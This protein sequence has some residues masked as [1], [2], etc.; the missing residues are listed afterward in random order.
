MECSMDTFIMECG[1]GT[2]PTRKNLIIDP[3]AVLHLDII[4][5]HPCNGQKNKT[6]KQKIY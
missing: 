6:D 1:Y 2:G 4:L 3:L 5:Y